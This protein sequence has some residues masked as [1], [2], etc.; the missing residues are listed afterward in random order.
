MGE[1]LTTDD[2]S[3][4][5]S[6]MTSRPSQQGGIGVS[7]TI[8]TLR[9]FESALLNSDWLK[10]AL[11]KHTST[12]K[13]L[14]ADLQ[15]GHTTD[16]ADGH[17]GVV[18]HR[19]P[20]L[21]MHDVTGYIAVS[22]I[23]HRWWGLL[24][25]LPVQGNEAEGP[26]ILEVDDRP[27]CPAIGTDHVDSVVTAILS[28]LT[29]VIRASARD[30]ASEA[31][32]ALARSVMGGGSIGRH[33]DPDLPEQCPVSVDA[34]HA[35]RRLTGDQL[36]SF[37]SHEQA[38][39]VQHVWEGRGNLLLV[40]PTGGGKTLSFL[41][42]MHMEREGNAR[43]GVTL[44]LEPFV[45]LSA[46]MVGR[47]ARSGLNVLPY[48]GS[49]A[50]GDVQ[51]LDCLVCTV[52]AL[53]TDHL[54][55]L[56]RSL[57]TLNLLARIVVDEA[58]H[59]L[60]SA[61]FRPVFELLSTLRSNPVP[62]LLLTAT[63]P[64][65]LVPNLLTAYSIT[66][67]RTIRVPTSRPEQLF[68]V[69][70]IPRESPPT[71]FLAH[72]ECHRAALL[73]GEKL[74]VFCSTVADVQLL[75]GAVPLSVG[76][77]SQMSHEDRARSMAAFLSD[78]DPTNVAV[79]T[80]VLSNGIDVRGLRTVLHYG[81]PRSIVD[82]VQESGRAGR[83][84]GLAISHVFPLVREDGS[85]ELP[86]GDE[87]GTREAREWVLDDVRC[88]RLAIGTFLDGQ[89]VTCASLP[90][91]L[92]CDVCERRL[93]CLQGFPN[94][95][96]EPIASHL[97][98]P[99]VPAQVDLPADELVA[100]EAPIDPIPL[101]V[102]AQPRMPTVPPPYPAMEV[103]IDRQIHLQD[104]RDASSEQRALST[105]LDALLERQQC[106]SCWCRGQ[107]GRCQRLSCFSARFFGMPEFKQMK[108]RLL[109]PT[110]HCWFC[111]IPQVSLSYLLRRSEP[112]IADAFLLF[113]ATL[114]LPRPGRERLPRH[115]QVQGHAP[116]PRLLRLGQSSTPQRRPLAGRGPRAIGLPPGVRSVVAPAIERAL[117]LP[118]LR[119]ASVG[120]ERGS[121]GCR[122]H[123]GRRR[124]SLIARMDARTVRSHSSDSVRRCTCSL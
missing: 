105:V 73:P 110:G 83:D 72:L 31:A 16:M 95:D 67:C 61:S 20:H 85:I 88:R 41:L 7:L 29:P 101:P 45:A 70:R 19:L 47:V 23:L 94:P 89:G 4:A 96:R 77:H 49:L 63:V 10:P 114:R 92:R 99:I 38:Q 124:A 39:A 36:A 50:L 54:T 21:R 14:L 6:S 123:Q 34:L 103:L 66:V 65:N 62:I 43:R 3:E 24:P 107:V 100:F 91:C 74:L 121:L 82:L 52:D 18:T 111:G 12:V 35:L 8:R 115:V 58:H 42:P 71:T 27:P 97:P 109:L 53:Q 76:Y 30:G 1:P 113:S 79:S 69:T 84:G 108:G 13:D 57:S 102:D 28:K 60:H 22:V 75:S 68:G 64:P 122:R 26:T 15:A 25:E 32:A 112:S 44:V 116:T 37:K 2:F 93:S 40:L 48:D 81:A 117:R 78:H 55:V 11:S 87:P 120:R 9:H 104:L 80:S 56:I 118:E 119:P 5:I 90:L 33:A 98:I 17:Y 51:G 59:A 46:D 106:L 86:N